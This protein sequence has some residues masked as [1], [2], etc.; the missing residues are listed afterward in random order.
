MT[1]KASNFTGRDEMLKVHSMVI[2]LPFYLLHSN[3]TSNAL[4]MMQILENTNILPMDNGQ[5][6]DEF[7]KMI[8]QLENKSDQKASKGM[9]ANHKKIVC[10]YLDNLAK[11]LPRNWVL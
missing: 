10:R 8:K 6:K 2:G 4:D 3:S 9:D 5:L 1:I 7:F 11:F